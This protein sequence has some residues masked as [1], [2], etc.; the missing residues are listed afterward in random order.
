MREWLCG[1]PAGGHDVH[2]YGEA[3]SVLKVLIVAGVVLGSC[4]GLCVL[5][6]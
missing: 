2:R 3:S 1:V 5:V 4:S 6:G